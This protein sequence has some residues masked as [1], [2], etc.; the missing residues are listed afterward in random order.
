MLDSLSDTPLAESMDFE[1][2]GMF[3]L[4][5]GGA[6]AAEALRTDPR[7]QTALNLDGNACD[8]VFD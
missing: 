2:V 5:L 8:F 3:G 1:R 4:S 7:I 6:T